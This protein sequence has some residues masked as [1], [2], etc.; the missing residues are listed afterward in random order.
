M[1]F[2]PEVK[3]AF[4]DSS[5][6]GFA[7]APAPAEI[8]REIDKFCSFCW[9][10]PD[11][12]LSTR[13]NAH[14][15]CNRFP[16]YKKK[17]NWSPK[18]SSNINPTLLSKLANLQGLSETDVEDRVVFYVYAILSS[19]YFLNIFSAKL[20]SLAGQWPAI[21][22]VED[23]LL[24]DDIVSIGKRLAELEKTGYQFSEDE[25]RQLSSFDWGERIN[26]F[27]VKGYEIEE[28]YIKFTSSDNRV[29]V[30]N[31]PSYVLNFS[32]SGYSIVREWLKY[33]SYAYY[34]KEITLLELEEFT[35]LIKRIIL[36][37]GEYSNLDKF[38]TEALSS[39]LIDLE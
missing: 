20:H 14:V 3:A 25:I 22:I 27:E 31:A 33:H 15:F 35:N 2:R 30:Y 32:V 21:P 17:K 5:V 10:M 28:D 1:R 26:S 39:K 38:V 37:I 9:H 6:L 8:S 4:S 23:K 13:G 12:D 29:I 16:E 34:R 19:P 11:N 36:Y 7:L 24:F 18:T